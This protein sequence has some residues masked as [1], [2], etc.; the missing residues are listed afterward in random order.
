MRVSGRCLHSWCHI[1]KQ[2]QEKLPLSSI[3][4][5]ERIYSCLK[6]V[7]NGCLLKSCYKLQ[8]C[9]SGGVYV[10]CITRMPG[11]SY[12]RRLRAFLWCLCDVFQALINSLVCRF[13]K[14]ALG[15]VLFQIYWQTQPKGQ[16]QNDKGY[17]RTLILIRLVI[18]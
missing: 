1:S 8:L 12:S 5:D 14:S 6:N 9:T 17:E 7:N 10:T 4:W 15:F 11:E 16:G 2:I 13:F 3:F 18:T